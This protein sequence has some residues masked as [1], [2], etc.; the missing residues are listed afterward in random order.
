MTFEAGTGLMGATLQGQ[1]VTA[2]NVGE[3]PAGSVVRLDDSDGVL[4][5]LH[6]G[7]WY[8]RDGCAWCYDTIGNHLRRLP[9]TLCHIPA[10]EDTP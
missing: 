9:G 1:R 7:M 6:D 3:L 10:K 2:D 5:H 4:I 8:W